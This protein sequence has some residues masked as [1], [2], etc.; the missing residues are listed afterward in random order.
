DPPTAVVA[1]RDGEPDLLEQ[2]L[3]DD[4]GTDHRDLTLAV[5]HDLF[6][7]DGRR[8]GRRRRT[9][10]AELVAWLEVVEV[11]V[12][13]MR[14]VHGGIL[15]HRDVAMLFLVETDFE[16]AVLTESAPLA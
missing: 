6:E 14:R 1:A 9:R 11:D 10:R 13:E 12:V 5:A 7:G 2:G 4:H 15:R 3:L 8:S 16:E